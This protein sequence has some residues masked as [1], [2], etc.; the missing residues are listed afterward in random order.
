[1]D[2]PAEMEEVSRR[3]QPFSLPPPAIDTSVPPTEPRLSSSPV[4]AAH[5]VQDKVMEVRIIDDH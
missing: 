5:V 1:M 3:L 2:I 4:L